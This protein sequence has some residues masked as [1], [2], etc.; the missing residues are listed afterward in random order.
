MSS[1]DAIAIVLVALITTSAVELLK[2]LT[3]L[4]YAFNRWAVQ[5]WL[6]RGLDLRVLRGPQWWAIVDGRWLKQGDLVEQPSPSSDE[7]SP[8][9]NKASP[10]SDKASPPSDDPITLETRVV[11]L[12]ACGQRAALYRPEIAQIAGQLN[13]LAEQLMDFPARDPLVLR[14]LAGVP[15][16][17]ARSESPAGDT[18]ASVPAP[19]PSGSAADDA[20]AAVRPPTVPAGSDP[21]ADLS[22][23]ENLAEGFR[24]A[25]ARAEGDAAAAA[26]AMETAPAMSVEAGALIDTRTRVTAL[27]QGRLNELQVAG[28]TSWRIVLL[29]LAIGIGITILRSPQYGLFAG[30]LAPFG[31]E[32][33]N[34]LRRAGRG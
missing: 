27:V 15:R 14:A 7:A 5:R 19:A 12:A 33:F 20:A 24:A 22:R 11:Q 13:L 9:S 6:W 18:P 2:D 23:L 16:R 21:D 28:R 17:T 30:L 10:S 8:R 34:V 29:A 26:I 32:L 4:R 3:P 31:H 25:L 1:S